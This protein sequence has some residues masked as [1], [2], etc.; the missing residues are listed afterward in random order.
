MLFASPVM[1]AFWDGV[2]LTP[3]EATSWITVLQTPMI[4]AETAT[5]TARSY[6]RQVPTAKTESQQSP[7]F[8]APPECCATL[9]S[10]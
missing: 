4:A 7:V 10:T 2:M 9:S 1:A 8:R 6:P 3:N 5:F